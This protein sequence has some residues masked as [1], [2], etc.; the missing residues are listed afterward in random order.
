MNWL[1]RTISKVF[2]KK[3][4][5]LDIPEESWQRC[6]QCQTM[7]YHTDL[8]NNL[9]VCHNCDFHFKINPYLRFKTLFD[10]GAFEEVEYDTDFNDPLKFKDLRT[11]KDRWHEAR[12]KSGSKEVM[13]IGVGSINGV[14]TCVCSMNW[15]F[16]GASVGLSG[17]EGLIAAAEKSCEENIP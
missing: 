2:S 8:E 9:M 6:P 13:V 16:M 3:K 12:A 10:N 4:K 1:T 15:F 11:Y 5:S 7:H 17:A 14:K